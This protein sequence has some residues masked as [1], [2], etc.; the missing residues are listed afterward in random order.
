MSGLFG[1]GGCG[2]QPGG[3]VSWERRQWCWWQDKRSLGLH[4]LERGVQL[5]SRPRPE[6][7]E[8]QLISAQ[9]AGGFFDMFESTHIHSPRLIWI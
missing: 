2:E 8:E 7:R 1:G 9:C 3:S 4:L 6:V 5:V